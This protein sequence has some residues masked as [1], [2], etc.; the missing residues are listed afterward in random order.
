MIESGVLFGLSGVFVEY[1]SLEFE[2]LAS[3]MAEGP[4]LLGEGKPV[5]EGVRGQLI[6]PD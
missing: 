2:V 6:L 1:L 4:F 3:V 5:H